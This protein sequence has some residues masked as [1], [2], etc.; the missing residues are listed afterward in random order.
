M[1]TKKPF[2]TCEGKKITFVTALEP[3]KCFKQIK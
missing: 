2:R 3:F 1:V